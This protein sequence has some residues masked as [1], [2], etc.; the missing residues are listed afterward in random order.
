[1]R[2]SPDLST[3]MGDVFA[4]ASNYT[5]DKKLKSVLVNMSKGVMPKKMDVMDGKIIRGKMSYPIPPDPMELANLVHDLLTSKIERKTPPVAMTTTR[6]DRDKG[7][8]MDE[9]YAF[10]LREA[11]RLGKDR[12]H[13]M[14]IW[15]MIFSSIYLDEITPID[16]RHKNGVIVSINR[17]NTSTPELLDR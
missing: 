6:R 9:M 14:K 16:I 4:E 10:A 15:G 8:N 7:F 11:E 1:M 13:G 3:Q 12:E 2:I 5:M 17:I